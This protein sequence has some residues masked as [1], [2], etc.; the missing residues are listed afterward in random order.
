[1]KKLIACLLA[2][3][4][5]LSACGA[6]NAQSAATP[7]PAAVETEQTTETAP[8]EDAAKTGITGEV[9]V[10]NPQLETATGVYTMDERYSDAETDE[11][12]FCITRT[13]ITTAAQEKLWGV[14]MDGGFYGM[15]AW[16]NTIEIYLNERVD[17]EER[18]T[19][20]YV[21][22]AATGS[23]EQ[24]QVEGDFAPGWYDDAALYQAN[25][26]N[27]WV[28][29]FTRLDRAT[30]ELTEQTFPAQTN[31]VYGAVSGRW[32]LTRINSA[33]PIPDQIA[34]ED[35]FNTAWKNATIEYILYDPASGVMEK[36]YEC[37]TTGVAYDYCG[38]R[39]GSLYFLHRQPKDDGTE[40]LYP[41]SIDKLEN[42]EMTPVW[43][44][45][46]TS[47]NVSAMEQQGQLRW[48]TQ[49]DEKWDTTLQVFDLTDGQ[50]Y[51]RTIEVDA[52][53]GWDVGYPLRLLANDKLL[54]SNSHY[55][56]D[57]GNER[58]AYAL[59]D[60]DAYLAGSTDYTPVT[61]YTGE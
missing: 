42:G 26:S 9:R 43:T 6:Q 4:L 14:K 39:D 3:P 47:A 35:I 1:M 20:R 61:M 41:A 51:T 19:W 55:T 37:P 7:A 59:I 28:E 54:A 32:L 46:Q 30:G 12:D 50:T 5:A 56:T 29:S 60:C 44:V 31:T 36:L 45:P 17:E 11:T 23:A 13:D 33:A 58:E 34:D 10:C 2:L 40:D 38:Q 8:A 22:D 57:K 53:G 27:L 18:K 15:A 48:I 21:I 52:V 49:L 16:D 24:Y 25:Y